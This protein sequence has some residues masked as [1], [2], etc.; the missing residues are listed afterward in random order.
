MYLAEIKISSI[1]NLDL[2]SLHPPKTGAKPGGIMEEGRWG[3]GEL[4]VGNK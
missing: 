4:S 1:S 3:G 2:T